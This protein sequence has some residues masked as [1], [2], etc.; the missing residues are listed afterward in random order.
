MGSE[1]GYWFPYHPHRSRQL[2]RHIQSGLGVF[3]YGFN[4]RF[5]GLHQRLITG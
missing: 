1:C 2:Q 4:I 3:E 5:M